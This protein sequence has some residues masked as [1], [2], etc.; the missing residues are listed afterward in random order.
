M[1]VLGNIVFLGFWAKEGQ[2]RLKIKIKF[3]KF[4]WKIDTQ[5]FSDLL[6]KVTVA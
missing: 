2:N 6:Y 5:N 1:I 3:L 4:L